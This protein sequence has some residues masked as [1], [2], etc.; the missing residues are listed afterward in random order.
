MGRESSHLT[1][2]GGIFNSKS[3]AGL[4]SLL[5]LTRGEDTTER[6]SLVFGG[7]KPSERVP[8]SGQWDVKCFLT[9][10]RWFI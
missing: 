1:A 5:V 2:R 3:P 10:Y 9:F 6:T 7:R 8:R 4:S